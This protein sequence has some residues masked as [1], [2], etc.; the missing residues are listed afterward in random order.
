MAFA[1]TSSIRSLPLRL[2]TRARSGGAASDVAGNM[3]ASALSTSAPE[4]QASLWTRTGS[5]ANNSAPARAARDMLRLY[6]SLQSI[7]LPWAREKQPREYPACAAALY[8]SL[9]MGER[10][11]GCAL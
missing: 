10:A 1:S 7:L 11:P 5:A 6:D 9:R 3:A 4:G 8:A 2:C